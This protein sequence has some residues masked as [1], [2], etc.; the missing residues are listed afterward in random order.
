MLNAF[1]AIN[2]Y[3]QPYKEVTHITSSRVRMTENMI[4]GNARNTKHATRRVFDLLPGN[5][6]KI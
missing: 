2:V 3:P 6:I 1:C 5:V 4:S